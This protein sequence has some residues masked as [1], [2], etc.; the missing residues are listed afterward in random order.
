[1]NASR[2]T[3]R[4]QPSKTRD[5]MMQRARESRTHHALRV[6]GCEMIVITMR[7]VSY[8]VMQ[9]R[10]ANRQHVQNIIWSKM[11]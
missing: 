7:P 11:L 10:R 8:Y 4:T 1:M 9:A 3:M 2:V 6:A 5:Y